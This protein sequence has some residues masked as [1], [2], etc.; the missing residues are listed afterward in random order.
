MKG[1]AAHLMQFASATG[2]T[3]NHP[4]LA[5]RA[6]KRPPLLLP[7][8]QCAAQLS[9]VLAIVPSARLR[10]VRAQLIRSSQLPLP[11]LPQRFLQEVPAAQPGRGGHFT[12]LGCP[13]TPRPGLEDYA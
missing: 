2:S 13:H 8:Q 1:A 4:S 6:S 9:Q 10:A 7:P 11:L 3:P 5:A 12:D